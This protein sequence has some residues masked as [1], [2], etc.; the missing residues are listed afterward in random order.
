LRRPFGVAQAT[1]RCD[2]V[3]VDRAAVLLTAAGPVAYHPQLFDEYARPKPL[4]ARKPLVHS[5][6]LFKRRAGLPSGEESRC[7]IHRATGRSGTIA[8]LSTLI[9]RGRR[10]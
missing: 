8:R 5:P 3:S 6:H 10:E 4:R 9:T 2:P 7:S 1:P